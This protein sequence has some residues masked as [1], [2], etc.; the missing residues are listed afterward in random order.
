VGE[1]GLWEMDVTVSKVIFERERESFRYCAGGFPPFR[2]GHFSLTHWWISFL[3]FFFYS[4][5]QGDGNR[6]HYTPSLN[7]NIEGVPISIQ[8]STWGMDEQACIRSSPEEL[9]QHAHGTC[10]NIETGG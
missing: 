2:N 7:I 8:K 9:L 3:L 4:G 10:N 6:K 1:V 5:V